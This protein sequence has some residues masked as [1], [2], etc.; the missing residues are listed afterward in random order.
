VAPQT[1]QDS[2][3][4]EEHGEHGQSQDNASG[5]IVDG[6]TGEGVHHQNH[7]QSAGLEEA[8]HGDQDV[9]GTVAP[10]RQPFAVARLESQE[11][12]SPQ[13][14]QR[15]AADAARISRFVSSHPYGAPLTA[16]D[17]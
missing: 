11:A 3:C 13:S 15:N 16:L 17:G 5:H 7:Q 1:S 6:K 14:M 9:S 8:E 10:V 2:Q 12:Q 4:D